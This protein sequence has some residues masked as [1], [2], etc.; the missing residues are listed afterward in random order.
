MDPQLQEYRQRMAARNKEKT[1]SSA[2]SSSLST[3]TSTT[4]PRTTT[5]NYT[6][7]HDQ[8]VDFFQSVYTVC[9]P[10]VSFQA[11]GIGSTASASAATTSED[12]NAYYEISLPVWQWASLLLAVL[13]VYVN[14]GIGMLLIILVQFALLFLIWSLID[15]RTQRKIKEFIFDTKIGVNRENVNGSLK[16]DVLKPNEVGMAAGGAARDNV[17]TT[18]LVPALPVYQLGLGILVCCFFFGA[19]VIGWVIAG[20]VYQ[21]FKCCVVWVAGSA[22][23]QHFF[24]MHF[25]CW[26][27]CPRVVFADSG[28]QDA[29]YHAS[30][31]HSELVFSRTL[32]LPDPDTTFGLLHIAGYYAYLNREKIR[33]WWD[34]VTNQGR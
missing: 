28:A 29:I 12:S 34:S 4:A 32:V 9:L 7:D 31:D 25:L 19:G 5:P 10:R 26:A 13:F 6:E 30:C 22:G 20:V 33:D 27:H 17:N 24:V 1:A 18:I 8:P 16:L 14:V 23:G 3:P 15:V 11:T 2:P 21:M